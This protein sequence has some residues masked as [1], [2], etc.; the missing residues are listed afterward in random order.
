MASPYSTRALAWAASESPPAY[1]VPSGYIFVMRDLD[2]YSG[3]G[4]IINWQLAVN[5]IA[6]V[7]AGQFTVESIAQVATWRGRQVVQAGE[8][9]EFA[10]DG[11]TDGMLSGY[12]LTAD[13]QP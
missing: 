1:Q 9:I 12:L 13:L 11:A 6:K 8:F 4:A 5:G 3:G 10:S 2:V 7:A